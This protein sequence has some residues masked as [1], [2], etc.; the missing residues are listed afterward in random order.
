MEFTIDPTTGAVKPVQET[1]ET[2]TLGQS[3]QFLPPEPVVLVQQIVSTTVID[4]I[5]GFDE[6]S[7]AEDYEV[8]CVPVD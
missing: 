2:E 4:I 8:R 6:V 7:N 3:L 1:Q 5:V